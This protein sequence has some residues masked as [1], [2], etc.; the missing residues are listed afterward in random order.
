MRPL[1]RREFFGTTAA[2]TLGALAVRGARSAQHPAWD[3]LPNILARIRPP[4]FPDRGFLITSFGADGDGRKDSTD[5]INRAISACSGAGGGR[6]EIPAGLFLSAAIRL[7]S[8]V[9]LHLARGAKL[10]FDRTPARYLPL[11]YTRWEGVECMN[12][13]AFIYADRVENIA[14]TEEGTLD[15]NCDCDHWWPWKGRTNC[16]WKKGMP[17]QETARQRLFAMGE[18]NVPVEKRTF[19]EESCLRPN[20]IQPCHSRN[21]LIEGVTIVNSPMWEIN[22]VLCGNVTVRGVKISSHGPNNDGCDPDS[23][24]DVLIENCSFDTGDDCIAIDSGRDRDGRRVG[25]ACENIVVR[26]CDMKDGHGALTIGSM[27]SGGVRNVFF[28]NC[29]LSSPH[30]DEVLRFKSNAM[31]GGVV[32][33]VFFRGIEIGEVA[34]AVVQIDLFYEDGPKGPERPVFRNIDIRDVTCR[35]AKYALKLRAFE[36]SDVSGIHLERCRFDNIGSKDVVENIHGLTF[37]DLSVNG[38]PRHG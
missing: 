12:Y 25:V 9:N 22:P 14:I 19:G 21:V 3:S 16:G 11:V 23:S 35:K 13:S 34:D 10:L 31:R 36:N 6:V 8:N 2:A 27:V 30:L 7:E 20:F 26:N 38:A 29:R 24:K 17:V 32:E 33:N 37:T 28:E 15:G 1:A 4:S 5:A 18:M